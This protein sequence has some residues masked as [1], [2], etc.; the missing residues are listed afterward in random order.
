MKYFFKILAFNN[1]VDCLKIL[2]EFLK[3]KDNIVIAFLFGSVVKGKKQRNQILIL[4][5]TLNNMMKSLFIL[6]GTNWKVCLK[7]M[8]TLLF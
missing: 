3:G 7:E 5:Y 2:K 1:S 8:L 6:Y 4:Q